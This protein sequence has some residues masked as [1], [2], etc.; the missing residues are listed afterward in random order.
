MIYRGI[1]LDRFQEEAIGRIHENASILV[2]A[3]TGAGKTLVAEYAVEKCISEGKRIIYTAPIKAI[4]NQKYRDFTSLYGDR[5]GIKTGDVTINPDAQVI[6]MTTEIFRNTV[7]ESPQTFRDVAYAIFDEIHFLDD[8]ERGTVWEESIIFAPEHIRFICLSATVPNLDEI[9]RWIKQVRP[10]AAFHTIIETERPIPLHQHIYIPGMGVK[11]LKDLHELERARRAHHYYDKVKQ[12]QA[13]YKW[14]SS[15]IDHLK[16]Q[17]RLPAIYFAFNRRECEEFSSQIGHSLLEKQDRQEILE[18][19]D[20]LCARFGIEPDA[21]SRH[22]RSMVG[23]GVAYHHAG[24]LPTLKEVIERIFTTGKLKLIFVTETFALG[25]NM[26]ARSV[27]FNSLHKFDGRRVSFL[28]TREHAQMSG[29]AG[30]RGLDKVG[31]VYSVGEWPHVRASIYERILHGNVEP[32]RSQ[33]NLSY[34]TLLTLW[35]HLGDKIYTAAEKSFSNFAS[36]RRKKKSPHGFAGK[37]AQM[38]KKLTLLRGLDYIQ[39][40]KLTRKGHFAKNLQGYELQVSELLFRGVL[41]KVPE[42]LLVMVFNAIAYEAKR[43]TWHRLIK[44]DPY[45]TIRKKSYRAVDDILVTEQSLQIEDRT[46]ELDFKLASAICAW[47]EG[48]SWAELE[49]HTSASD[50][51]LVR[52]FRLTIQLLRN[53]MFALD[54]NHPLRPA[55]RNSLDNVNRDVVDAERQLRLG[56]DEDPLEPFPLEEEDSIPED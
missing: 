4:S 26:P 56:V 28:R 23:K 45:R 9:A 47:S 51:D 31:H 35:E 8:I 40:G 3:P 48:C 7:F 55:L 36:K 46:K 20:K 42:H 10:E 54:R 37:I 29:R 21:N 41:E 5:V 11:R 22:L 14:R 2:A 24:L 13:S 19:F 34:A 33:F 49:K 12:A 44:V 6:L 52:Y 16:Q 50:G 38:K 30:R 39:G 1:T 17:N 15:L 25:I 43:S 27:V 53:T 18:I 32:I